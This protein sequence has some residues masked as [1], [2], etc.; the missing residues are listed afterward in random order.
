MSIGWP[1]QPERDKTH[2]QEGTLARSDPDTAGGM[3]PREAAGWTQPTPKQ[4]EREGK[5]GAGERARGKA[6]KKAT[7]M[8]ASQQKIVRKFRQR[9]SKPDPGA[10]GAKRVSEGLLGLVA[11]KR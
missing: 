8:K 7:Q 4:R 1:P 3:T 2:H 5:G 11:G 9:D 6:D 10:A